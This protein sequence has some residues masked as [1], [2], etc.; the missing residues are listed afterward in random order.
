[1][2]HYDDIQ[3]EEYYPTDFVE[4]VY[5]ELSMKMKMTKLFNA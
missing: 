1:M 5:D 3:L 2:D 4:E